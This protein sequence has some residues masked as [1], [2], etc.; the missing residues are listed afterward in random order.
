MGREFNAGSQA[1]SVTGAVTGSRAA[2]W[3]VLRALGSLTALAWVLWRTPLHSIMT[4]MA[5]ASLPLVLI[6]LSLNV[7]TRLAAAERTQ[8]ICRGLRLRVSRWQNIET[9]FISNFYALLSPGPV[10]S[11]VVSV[12]RYSRFGIS[13][14]D[15][16]GVLLISRAIEAAV[17]IAIGAGCLWADRRVPLAAVRDPLT[18]ATALLLLMAAAMFLWT[19]THRKRT[20]CGA[21]TNQAVTTFTQR[22][23]KPLV[24]V[25]HEL[26]KRGPALAWQAA[27]PAA[28]QVLMAGVALDILARALGAEL[29]LVT[30]IWVNAAV[31]AAVLLPISIAGV[32]VRE[33]TL[34]NALGL[35]GVRP[36]LTVALALLLF[37]DPLLNALIGGL[38]QIRSST[39]VARNLA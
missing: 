9:L 27:M 11:G 8:A 15:G 32:G 36:E 19:R 33:F 22:W 14:S 4:V 28:V 30:A 5:R 3:S 34:L 23:L 26:M 20:A 7:L 10:L 13:V 2:L 24:T 38:L 18:A 37:A 17:F 31:Y 12:Y 35:V 29:S 1:V 39:Y 16:L 6:G 21:E 25:R